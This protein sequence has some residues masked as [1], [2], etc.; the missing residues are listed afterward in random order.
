[1]TGHLK[2]WREFLSDGILSV[3]TS[4]FCSFKKIDKDE[5]LVKSKIG[6]HS[7]KKDCYSLKVFKTDCKCSTSI[8][9]CHGEEFE[10][11]TSQDQ[12][13]SG[14]TILH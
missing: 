9:S 5:R 4:D 13:L 11:L 6:V 12:K 1:M 3:G 8:L 14:R 2:N 10:T 7:S